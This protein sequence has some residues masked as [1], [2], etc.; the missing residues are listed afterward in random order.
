MIGTPRFALALA[1]ALAPAVGET[2]PLWDIT[3]TMGL[4]AGH[5]PARDHGGYQEDWFQAALGGVVLGRH[6]SRHV[7]VELEASGT[8][9]G[10]QYVSRLVEVPGVP[11]RYPIASDAATSVRSIGGLVTW[12]FRNNEWVHPYVQAGMSADFDHTVLYTPEQY[13]YGD[14]RTGAPPRLIAESR[15][16]EATTRHVRSAIGGGAKVYFR[17]RA[18]VRTD[19]RLTFAAGR[20]NLQFRVG[21]GLDF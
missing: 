6:L 4:F 7:K 16:D 15:I 3:A 1:L 11:G 21:V 10:L 14:S 20:E 13:Y 2:Q 18:F 12:Q 9:D 8:T 5:R 19:A 17:E